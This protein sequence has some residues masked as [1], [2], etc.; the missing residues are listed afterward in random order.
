MEIKQQREQ[1]LLSR[2]CLN[3][4]LAFEGATPSNHSLTNDIASSLKTK[5]SLVVVKNITTFFGKM[6]A[7]FSAIV[8]KDESSL[9][10]YEV[11][12]KRMKDAEAKAVKE[13]AEA[14]AAK[15]DAEA[16]AA[17]EAAEAKKAEGTTGVE[18]NS[19]DGDRDNKDVGEKAQ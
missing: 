2:T 15:E 14:K 6:E 4:T 9:H 16:K 18:G 3:G 12:T 1:P 5:P 17:K 8:Y 13:A 11:K 19:P 7:S 10:R